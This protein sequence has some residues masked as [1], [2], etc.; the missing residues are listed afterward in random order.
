MAHVTVDICTK[1]RY[2]TTLPQTLISVATQTR[3]PDYIVIYDDSANPIDIGANENLM[4]IFKLFD[5]KGIKWRHVWGKKLGQHFGHHMVQEEATEF[6]WRI[7][8]DEVAEPNVLATLLSNFFE[9]GDETEDQIMNIGAV[10][11]LVLMPGASTE[12]PR[13]NTIIDA[14]ANK[15][16][17]CQWHFWKHPKPTMP[18]EH[19]YSS[20]LYRKGI[21]KYNTDLSPVAH[22][23]ETL[24]SYG[25]FKAGYKLIIDSRAVTWHFRSGTG[26]IRTGKQ[27]DWFRDEITFHEVMNEYSGKLV[28]YLDSGM[29]DHVVFKTAVL[30]AI[31]KKYSDVTLAVCYPELFPGEKT[32][33]IAEGRNHCNPERHNICRWMEI[34]NWRDEMKY[35]YAAMYGVEIE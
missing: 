5:T 21:Q 6:I 22:R 3:K 33:S 30:P 29:G 34:N 35:A 24:H 2:L 20:Y 14:M 15:N 1:D 26:G 13:Q 18:V 23:E 32:I 9:D 25:I 31:K 12:E 10:G 4:Y 16:Y 17:N 28:A 11:G 8:D 27:E 7:D 19:I